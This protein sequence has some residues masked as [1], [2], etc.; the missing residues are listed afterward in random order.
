MDIKW[1]KSRRR[2]GM[3]WGGGSRVVTPGSQSVLGALERSGK[4]SSPYRKKETLL[5]CFILSCRG[6]F[7]TKITALVIHREAGCAF[8]TG[9]LRCPQVVSQVLV[10]QAAKMCVQYCQLTEAY[11]NTYHAVFATGGAHHWCEVNGRELPTLTTRLNLAIA[12][13]TCFTRRIQ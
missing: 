9:A 10:M 12:Q 2:R 13:S 1:G 6:L 5:V 8:L 4:S 3:G 7:N 11:S